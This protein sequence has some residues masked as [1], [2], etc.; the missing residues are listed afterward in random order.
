MNNLL[1]DFNGLPFPT[2]KTDSG[3]DFGQFVKGLQEEIKQL[4]LTFNRLGLES[5]PS[6]FQLFY[7]PGQCG[8]DWR[9]DHLGGGLRW[10][11]QPG[12][13]AMKPSM[14]VVHMYCFFGR[15]RSAGCWRPRQQLWW[16]NSESLSGLFYPF[17][18]ENMYFLCSRQG[19]SVIQV[20]LQFSR[21]K[22][23]WGCWNLIPAGGVHE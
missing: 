11:V 16:R 22:I 5:V 18:F 21:T 9:W 7:F 20:G 17:F 2:G 12:T 6:F 19:L 8:P 10:S 23:F 3:L 1:L 4:S 13:L 15:L 14:Q